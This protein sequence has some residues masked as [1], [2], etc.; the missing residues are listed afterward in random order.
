M[1]A[2]FA[3]GAI[4][5]GNDKGFSMIE[6]AIILSMTVVMMAVAIPMLSS[7]IQDM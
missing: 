6:L 7:S 3:I 5:I 4:N 1:Q 2:I